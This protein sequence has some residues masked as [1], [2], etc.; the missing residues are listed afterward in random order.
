MAM[1]CIYEE[2]QYDREGRDLRR[3]YVL[4]D[5]TPETMPTDGSTIDRLADSAILDTGSVIK[6]LDTGKKHV[7][8]GNQW[9]DS[10]G[11]SDSNVGG[12]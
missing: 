8:Y 9:Y 3:V 10:D 5:E 4:A 12:E 11:N 1:T 6:C 2:Q 7:R